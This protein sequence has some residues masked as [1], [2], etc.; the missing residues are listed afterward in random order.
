MH[1]LSEL[2]LLKA[3]YCVKDQ[4]DDDQFMEKAKTQISDKKRKKVCVKIHRNTG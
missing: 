2:L 3:L 1:D 4:D